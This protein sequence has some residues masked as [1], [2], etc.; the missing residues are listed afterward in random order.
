MAV[1][2]LLMFVFG[3]FEFARLLYTYH[4]VSTA[5]RLATRWAMV[6]GIDCLAPSCPAT[7]SSVTTYVQSVVPLLNASNVS[8]S[9]SWSNTGSCSTGTKNGPGC[10][11]SV[12]VT[13]PFTFELPLVSNARLSLTSTSQ[14]VISE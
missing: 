8:V 2:A 12:T 13:Y 9:A 10:L 4:T 1:M 6:R 7:S 5:A 3:I 14:M 11:V